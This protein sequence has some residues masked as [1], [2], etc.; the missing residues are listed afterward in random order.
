MED[1]FQN[2]R[3]T[4]KGKKMFLIDY[5]LFVAFLI[6]RNSLWPIDSTS[7]NQDHGRRA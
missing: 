4:W 1:V 3:V 2:R 6:F 5:Q 7:I